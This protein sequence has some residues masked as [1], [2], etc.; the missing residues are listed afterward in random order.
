MNAGREQID[1]VAL[2]RIPGVREI[3]DTFAFRADRP[4]PWLQRA[5]LWILRKL[6]CWACVDTASIERH[7][8]GKNGR[9]F[10]E[11]LWERRVAIQGSFDFDPTRLLIG[12]QEY[13][14]L[15]N[16]PVSNTGFQFGAEWRRG[17]KHGPIVMGLEVEVI[18]WMSGMLLLR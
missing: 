13:A 12:A 17:S 18:P 1:V 16:E 9:A 3:N 15:M 2:R 7:Y 11:R 5:C 4:A 10:M 6:G 8:I 14:E